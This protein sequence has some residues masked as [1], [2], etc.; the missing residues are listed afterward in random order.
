MRVQEKKVIKKL[1]VTITITIVI[2]MAFSIPL[3]GVF[4][5][6]GDII[7]PGTGLWKVPGELPEEET[8]YIEG[9]DDEVIVY[10]DEWGVPHI[11]AET[12][13]DLFFVLGYIHAQDRLFSMDVMRRYIRGQLSEV[14]GESALDT[15]I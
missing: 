8:L 9:L 14:F 4:A 6:M 12:E 7:I 11:Y 10:R 13:D 15:D 5:P 2:F 3:M 1:S